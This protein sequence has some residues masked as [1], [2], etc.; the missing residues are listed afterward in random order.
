MFNTLSSL[1]SRENTKIAVM[2]DISAGHHT[3]RSWLK[4]NHHQSP[5]EIDI[6]LFRDIISQ[7]QKTM[8]ELLRKNNLRPVDLLESKFNV[9]VDGSRITLR[10]QEKTLKSHCEVSSLPCCRLAMVEVLNVHCVD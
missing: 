6:S 1:N 8:A 2:A 10:A 4:P 7:L 9:K 5:V 3:R